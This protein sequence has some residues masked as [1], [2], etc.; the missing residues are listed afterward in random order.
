MWMRKQANGGQ[1]WLIYHK[2][3]PTTFVMT[4][5]WEGHISSLHAWDGYV[6][7]HLSLTISRIGPGCQK[8]SKR[9]LAFIDWAQAQVSES[10]MN[11]ERTIR[12]AWVLTWG[13]AYMWKTMKKERDITLQSQPMPIPRQ[14]KCIYVNQNNMHE[15][16][17]TLWLVNAPKKVHSKTQSTT[18]RR[19]SCCRNAVDYLQELKKRTNSASDRSS[20]LVWPK[21]SY[22]TNQLKSLKSLKS[23]Q[24]R[25]WNILVGKLRLGSFRVLTFANCRV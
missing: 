23:L 6:L 2:N 21:S 18:A 16:G 15:V 8:G 24:I 5:P 19:T 25:T 22:Q 3:R 11:N 7:C 13:H 17:T 14:R 9:L 1:T 10:N 20:D 4:R 12:W